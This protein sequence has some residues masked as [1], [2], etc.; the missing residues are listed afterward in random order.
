MKNDG[1][2]R[3]NGTGFIKLSRRLLE[4]EWIDDPSM[5]T[6]WVHCLL[7]ANWKD[8]RYHGQVIPRG[9]FITSYK[10][11]AD[12]CGLSVSTI[13]RCFDKLENSKQIDR[14]VTHHGTLVKVRN[15]AVFQDCEIGNPHAAEHLPEQ[16]GEHF[17]EHLPEQQEKN[18]K[19]IRS[20][21][22]KKN[23]KKKFFSRNRSEALPEYY[24]AEPIRKPNPEPAT[25]EEVEALRKQLQRRTT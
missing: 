10:A 6:V 19:N 9:S 2:N 13:R 18:I 22:V 11:F 5:V 24:N 4:W 7:A 21:E 20:K 15:Y 25:P 1:E 14:Q 23:T 16:T 17:P 8:Y 3:R 12:R